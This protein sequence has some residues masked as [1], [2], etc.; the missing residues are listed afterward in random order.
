MISARDFGLEVVKTSGSEELVRCPFHADSSPS[1][2][3]STTKGLFHCFV[4]DLGLNAAQL[5]DR[6]GVE[7]MEEV[8]GGYDRPADYDLVSAIAKFDLGV[9]DY[10]DYFKQRGISKETAWRYD[11]HWN[12]AEPQAAVLPITNL[13]GKAVGAQYRYVNPE[14]SGTRYKVFGEMTPLWPMHLLKYHVGNQRIVVTEGAWSAMK[15]HSWFVQ[16]GLESATCLS[17]LGAKASVDMV[18]ALHPFEVA[19][20]YDNDFAGERACRKMRALWPT[21]HSWTLSKSPDDMSEDE[22]SQ[23]LHK[24]VER[25]E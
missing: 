23:M 15:I 11:M 7:W 24:L 1:A 3:F 17:T 20:L 12:Y 10:H 8:A 21:A 6:L 25:F 16:V 9:K 22:I 14:L 2:T 5:A 13:N 18:D 4:C 19:F